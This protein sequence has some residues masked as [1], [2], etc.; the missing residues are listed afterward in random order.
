MK[1]I[2]GD[3]AE[4]KKCTDLKTKLPSQLAYRK[5]HDRDGKY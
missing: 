5:W 1:D 3:T 2:L 4:Y